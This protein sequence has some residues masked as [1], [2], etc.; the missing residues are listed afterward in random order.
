LLPLKVAES[1][2]AFSLSSVTL[3]RSAFFQLSVASPNIPY[4]SRDN[5]SKTDTRAIIL[6]TGRWLRPASTSGA[7]W[8]LIASGHF[9]RA[10][11]IPPRELRI[12]SLG[13]AIARRLVLQSRQDALQGRICRARQ[14]LGAASQDI[15]H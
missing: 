6:L 15:I 3:H 13:P 7:N 14:E 8:N 11:A 2:R 10:A 12:A 1:V 9:L 5:I 4:V